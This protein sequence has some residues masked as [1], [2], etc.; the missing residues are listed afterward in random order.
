MVECRDAFFEKGSSKQQ[1]AMAMP[2]LSHRG[3]RGSIY[4]SILLVMLL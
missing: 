2:T 3:L 4:C 1:S